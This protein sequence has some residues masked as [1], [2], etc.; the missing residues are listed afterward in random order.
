MKKMTCEM[1]GSTELIK[2]DGLFVCQ[3]C[4]CKYSVE[5]ARKLLIEIDGPVEVS[6]T[7]KVD[8]SASV[9]SYLTMAQ[10]ALTAQNHNQ[11]VSDAIQPSHHLSSPSPLALNLSQHQGLFK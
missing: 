3:S 10:A 2:Q 11:C 7:V 6:G 8:Q 9:D 4:G 1:C 5:E